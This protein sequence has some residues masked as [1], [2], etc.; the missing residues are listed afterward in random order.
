MAS[1]TPS[2]GTLGWLLVTS[3]F[4]AP[5]LSP[6]LLDLRGSR[7]GC[8][9]QLDG[10]HP[11]STRQGPSCCRLGP[12]GSPGPGFPLDTEWMLLDIINLNHL[13]DQLSSW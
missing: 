8:I 6:C 4:G 10:C 12:Q 7:E 13:S 1:I 2:S 3:P 5:A 11:Q 9:P